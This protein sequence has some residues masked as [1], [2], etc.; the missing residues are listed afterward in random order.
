M[1]AEPDRFGA[2]IAGTVTEAVGTADAD[3]DGAGIVGAGI[4]GAGTIRAG[5]GSSRMTPRKP[6]SNGRLIEI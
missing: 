3:I 2:D 4:V 6:S 1:G 5:W